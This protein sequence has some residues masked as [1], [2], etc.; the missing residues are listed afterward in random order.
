MPWKLA[1]VALIST[2]RA[3]LAKYLQMSPGAVFHF[4]SWE[5]VVSWKVVKI[6]ST[7][8][9]VLGK[10]TARAAEISATIVIIWNPL[11]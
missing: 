1:M 7:L 10:K 4:R 5:D 2:A 6:H 8:Y 3:A 11:N 9:E